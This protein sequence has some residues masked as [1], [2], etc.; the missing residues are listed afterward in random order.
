LSARVAARCER[1][2]S[3]ANVERNA[4]ARSSASAFDVEPSCR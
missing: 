3:S 1:S 4:S 2:A